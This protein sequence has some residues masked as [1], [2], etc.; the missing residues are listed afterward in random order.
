MNEKRNDEDRIQSGAGSGVGQSADTPFESQQVDQE[1]GV[2]AIPVQ[3]IPIGIPMDAAEFKKL[4]A[5]AE[6]R[7]IKESNANSNTKDVD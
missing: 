4:K 2:S 5:E 3:E 6:Q 7:S 1:E